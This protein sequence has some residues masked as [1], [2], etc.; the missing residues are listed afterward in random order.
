MWAAER[1]ELTVA[2]WGREAWAPRSARHCA[3]PGWSWAPLPRA[4]ELTH[5]RQA[6]VP[7]SRR[8]LGPVL[9]WK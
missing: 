2:H 6:R 9:P 8:G 4:S 7:C 3:T 1:G 5:S